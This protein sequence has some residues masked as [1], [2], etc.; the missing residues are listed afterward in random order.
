[1][2][3]HIFMAQ[4]AAVFMFASPV[5]TFKAK[6]VHRRQDPNIP[7]GY[8]V[9]PLHVTGN[10]NGV[11][12]NHT[13]TVQEVFK[14]LD[15]EDNSFKLSDLATIKKRNPVVAQL[16]KRSMTD[17]KCC[18][19]PGQNWERADGIAIRNGINYLRTEN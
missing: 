3:P 17:V 7:E 9:R 11:V 8:T 5:L 4:L 15:A 18:P 16:N 6:G 19:V 14:Q 10:I 13:G 1:M 2:N 12:I